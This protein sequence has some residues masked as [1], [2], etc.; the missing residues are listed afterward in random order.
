MKYIKTYEEV[1][2]NVKV[3]DQVYCIEPEV[4]MGLNPG[5][6]YTVNAIRYTSDGQ[7]IYEIDDGGEWFASRFTKDKN[8]PKLVNLTANKYNL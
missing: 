1:E 8:H 6:L 7:T 4:S 3:G 5:E 2:D